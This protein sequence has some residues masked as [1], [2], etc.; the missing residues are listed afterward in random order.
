MGKSDENVL[1]IKFLLYYFESMSGMMINY[2]KSEVFVIGCEVEEQERIANTF[3]CKLGHLPMVYLDMPIGEY[4][5]NNDQFLPL[6][7]KTT[8]KMEPWQ[9]KLMSSAARLTL[10]NACLANLPMFQ[11]GFYLLGEGVHGELDKVRG[12]FYWEGCSQDFKY[13]MMKWEHVCR[14]KD[15]EGLGIINTRYMNVALL[16]KWIWK[17]FNGPQDIPWVQLI[18]KKYL[19]HGESILMN[20]SKGSQFWNGLQSVKQWFVW[21]AIHIVGDGRRTRFWH[22]VWVGKIPLRVAFP[23]LFWAA[24]SPESSVIA[25][26]CL[27]SHSWDI[28]FR[29]TFCAADLQLWEQLQLLLEP[30]FLSG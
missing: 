24:S 16:L 15:F 13:H 23:S 22:D 7:A 1:H 10:S 17:L 5:L 6:V 9:G 25:N 8:K 11:M 18:N 12:R 2:Y 14:P 19:K 29:R 26:Y 30:V 28:K 3:N 27:D 21:G 20:N 4:K